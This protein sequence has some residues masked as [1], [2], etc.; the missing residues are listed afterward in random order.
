[1]YKR[2]VEDVV[3]GYTP[4]VTDPIKEND[5]N[6]TIAIRNTHEL[7]TTDIVIKKVW[8]DLGNIRIRRDSCTNDHIQA[9]EDNGV[10]TSAEIP[11]K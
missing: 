3:K 2:Q 6:I 5:N 10:R 8:D 4:T 9:V 7:E 1:M 11:L